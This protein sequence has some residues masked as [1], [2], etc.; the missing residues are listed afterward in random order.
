MT[1]TRF[2]VALHILVM[3]AE[4]GESL[5]SGQLAASVGTNSSYIRKVIGLL[6]AAKIIEGSQGRAGYALCI[7]PEDLTLFAIYAA[8]QGVDGVDLF[9]MHRNPNQ[10]C[11]VGRCIHAGLKP[12]FTEIESTIETQLSRYT[13][14][15][16][17]DDLYQLNQE[18]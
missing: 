9:D 15:T 12:I 17:I 14:R 18:N 6:Q 1:D 7:A 13:L 2:A 10:E 5:T 3:I 4:S 8:T 11:P 16:V